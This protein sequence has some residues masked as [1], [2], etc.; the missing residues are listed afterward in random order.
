M[1]A[2][3]KTTKPYSF[4]VTVDLET[5]ERSCEDAIRKVIDS[6]FD[7]FAYDI[8]YDKVDKG[9]AEAVDQDSITKI[10]KH[11]VVTAI[12]KETK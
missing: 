5:I 8:L 4:N 9:L 6:S 12:E 3:K 10:I 7:D 11:F 1:P 2:K